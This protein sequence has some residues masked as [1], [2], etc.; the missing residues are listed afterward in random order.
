[1]KS[2]CNQFHVLGTEGEEISSTG[3]SI[4]PISVLKSFSN[5]D[6]GKLVELVEMCMPMTSPC[7]RF[8]LLLETNLR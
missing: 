5:F 6:V 3:H 4:E 7:M 1:V 8:L 2:G